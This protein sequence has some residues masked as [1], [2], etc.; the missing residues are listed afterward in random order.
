MRVK[1]SAD[2]MR[3]FSFSGF[4]PNGQ[5]AAF[6]GMSEY[7]MFPGYGPPSQAVPYGY[8]QNAYG[9]P[10]QDS[11]GPPPAGDAAE[12]PAAAAADLNKK[13]TYDVPGNQQQPQEY[14]QR[15]QGPQN[16]SSAEQADN[17]KPY[18]GRDGPSSNAEASFNAW[19]P[20]MFGVFPNGAN[21]NPGNSAGRGEVNQGSSN[22]S[23]WERSSGTTVIAN[24][25]SNGRN[26]VATSHAI[27]YGNPR[28]ASQK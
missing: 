4:N 24:S 11:Y 7:S 5:M 21:G 13:Q 25:V 16:G 8:G 15:P 17:G 2:P 14:G 20:I 10:D 18:R 23:G 22:G 12:R 27:S 26:G 28:S 9:P 3:T 1:R 19:F 6:T